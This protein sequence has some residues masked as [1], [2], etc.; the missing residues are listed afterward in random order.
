VSILKPHN[1]GQYLISFLFI[2]VI[3]V[4]L[5]ADFGILTGPGIAAALLGIYFTLTSRLLLVAMISVTAAACSFIGQSMVAYCPYCTMAATGFLITGTYSLLKIASKHAVIAMALCAVSVISVGIFAMSI[6]AY[7]DTRNPII[8]NGKAITYSKPIEDNKP[9]LY[10]SPTCPSCK[11]VMKEFVE[12]DP[13]GDKWQPV[14]IPHS[15]LV[16]GEKMLR[17]AG[18][19]GE[20][21][22]ASNSPGNRIPVLEKNGEILSGK[23][24][25]FEEASL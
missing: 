21:I 8:E 10:L 22:S 18:Y 14:I 4:L 24:I 19:E 13:R 23:K 5:Y 16:Q 15:S 6:V 7:A 11:D 17:E 20:V 12:S 9:K 2:L 1:K 25:T 3:A